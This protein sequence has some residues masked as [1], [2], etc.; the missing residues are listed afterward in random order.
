MWDLV[1][2]AVEKSP[3][4]RIPGVK[5]I[6]HQDFTATFYTLHFFFNSSYDMLWINK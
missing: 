6:L 3:T 1:S 5:L 4:N 2:K